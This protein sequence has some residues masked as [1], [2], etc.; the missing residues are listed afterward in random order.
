M[1]AIEADNGNAWIWRSRGRARQNRRLFTICEAKSFEGAGDGRVLQYHCPYSC[2]AL[3][4]KD[5]IGWVQFHLQ[6]DWA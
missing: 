3:F 6:G 2:S 1:G 4:G 5:C